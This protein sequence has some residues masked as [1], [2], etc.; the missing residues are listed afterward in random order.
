MKRCI[1]LDW[2]E[3][4]ALEPVARQNN[5]QFF[6][7]KGWHVSEREYGTR[8]YNEMFTLHDSQTD[9]RLIEVR[10]NP[11]QQGEG[12]VLPIN[13]SHIRLTNRTCYYENAAQIMEDFLRKY[14]YEF[15]SIY[16]VDIALDFVTFD[17]GD[18][19]A[20]FIRRYM[21]GKYS[22]INQGKVHAH[23]DDQWSQR[24]WNSLSWGSPHSQ[25]STKMYKKSRELA[26][27]GDK[28]YI[29]YAWFVS[30][31]IDNPYTLCRLRRG[32]YLDYPDIWRVEF[33][34]KS[35]VKG[36]FR[37]EKD[38]QKKVKRSIRNVLSMYK[39]SEALLTMFASLQDHYFHF[40]I[41]EKG[42]RK[43][44]CERKK[45]FDFGTSE[46]CYKVEHPSSDLKKVPSEDRLLKYLRNYRLR[47]TQMEDLKAVDRL[48]DKL[49]SDDMRRL[50]ENPY[51]DVELLILQ[52]VIA[53]KMENSNKDVNEI[54][55]WVKEFITNNQKGLQWK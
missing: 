3:V 44:E 1:N 7:E 43:Y 18:N 41:F 14:E 11:K 31:L 34:I 21:E 50:C 47:L 30:G 27:V 54:Y 46:I 25:I 19:P 40:R 28:P 6:Q 2:L 38:G 35:N 51:S 37:Y 8:I 26:E 49:Q 12:S 15:V 10:R 24:E 4:Y 52:R 29:R 22:K 20:K 48:I 42:K 16:R 17:F 36:W 32:G 45:L 53:E 39:G 5:A 23:G 55:A 13:A 9:Y 33:S